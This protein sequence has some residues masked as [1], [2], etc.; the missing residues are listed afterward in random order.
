M[1]GKS[2]TASGPFQIQKESTA[3]C[4][5][6]PEPFCIVSKLVVRR[7]LQAEVI[8]KLKYACEVV[9]F[10]QVVGSVEPSGGSRGVGES[11]YFG[12]CST[13]GVVVECWCFT[14]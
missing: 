13:R 3:S 4:C 10:M 6:Q 9:G 5:P 11:R 2:A 14:L 1:T 8:E 7:P 12:L